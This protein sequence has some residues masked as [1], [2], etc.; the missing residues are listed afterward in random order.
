MVEVLVALALTASLS[1]IAVP[2]Y[3]DQRETA[4]VATAVTDI[5]SMSL[6]L[7]AFKQVNGRYPDSLGAA[8]LG[9]ALDPWGQRYGYAKIEGAV[10]FKGMKMDRFLVPLNTDYDL[11]SI[12]V[13]GVT[14]V[15]LNQAS[16]A[17]DV[18]RAN[19]GE[20]VGL[21]ADY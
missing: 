15:Q 11:Y 10:G 19:N 1:A 7:E 5:V 9:A 2:A 6:D 13:D 4:R 20:Y 16:S 18:V 3:M 17:D 14:N 12:G 8:G 21:G